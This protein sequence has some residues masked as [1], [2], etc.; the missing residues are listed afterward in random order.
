MIIVAMEALQ[1][2]A[3]RE[4]VISSITHRLGN[5]VGRTLVQ[6]VMCEM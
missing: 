3:R 2:L 6:D 4:V 1:T 5:Q